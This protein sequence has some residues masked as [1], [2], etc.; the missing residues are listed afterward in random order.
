MAALEAAEAAAETQPAL[1]RKDAEATVELEA[2][3]EAAVAAEVAVPD[4]ALAVRGREAQVAPA[5]AVSYGCSGSDGNG[6]S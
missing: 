6:Y 1:S 2:T 3:R 5:R 4:G